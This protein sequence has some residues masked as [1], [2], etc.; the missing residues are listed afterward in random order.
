[1]PNIDPPGLLKH[2]TD[3]PDPRAA[4]GI[5]HNLADIICIA[6]LAVICNANTFPEIHTFALLKQDWLSTFLELPHGIPSQDTFERLFRILNPGAWQSRFLEW[7][8][9]LTFA[10]LPDGHD[11]ILAVDGKTSRRSH[12]HG[13]GAL[14][15]VSV[16]SSQHE[17][18]LARIGV[19]DK[20]NEITVIPELLEI[21][22]PAGAVITIDAMGTQKAIAWTIREYHAH[23]VLA[24][25][26]N[27]PNLFEDTQWLFDHADGMNWQ[28]IE[29]SYAKT[30]DQGHGRIETRECWVLGNL[31]IIKERGAWRD[32]NAVVRVRGT[33]T[34]KGL[35]SVEDRLFITSLPVDAARVMR[36][37]RFHWGIENGLHWVLDVQFDEDDS[38][39]RAG[40]SQANLV[41][42]RHLALSVLKRDVS[43]KGG[44]GTKRFRAGLDEAYLLRLLKS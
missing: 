37:V 9:T 27:H 11:E 16:W 38:R 1:M 33:R 12:N 23:Y 34:F 10:A 8:Q 5:R 15:T 30:V 39:V 21:V 41:A 22:Q 42:V 43:V 40:N 35:T 4:R 26:D 29:H 17:I 18:T 19:P 7:T 32:L 36:A 31:E 28:N 24:L 25:K 3:L 6:V 20:T 14:H 13:T 44:V 2:F